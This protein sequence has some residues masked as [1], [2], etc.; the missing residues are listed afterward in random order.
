MRRSIDDLPLALADVPP[1]V[2]D[3]T[4]VS[5]GVAVCDDYDDATPRVVLTVEEIGGAGAGLVAHLRPDHARRLRGALHDALR[6]IG[7]DTGR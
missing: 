7:E 3:V 4:P 1:G 5:W 6:E 2:D